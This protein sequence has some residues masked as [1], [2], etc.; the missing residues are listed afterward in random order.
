MAASGFLERL[1]CGSPD[2]PRIVDALGFLGTAACG[3]LCF[4]AC[5]RGLRCAVHCDPDNAKHEKDENKAGWDEH[6]PPGTLALMENSY[7]LRTEQQVLQVEQTSEWRRWQRIILA[8]WIFY[9]TFLLVGAYG[10]AELLAHEEGQRGALGQATQT[11]VTAVGPAGQC[12]SGS[13]LTV[14]TPRLFTTLCKKSFPPANSSVEVTA[15]LTRTFATRPVRLHPVFLY[16]PG[17]GVRVAVQSSG[18]RYLRTRCPG[19]R[20]GTHQNDG[21]EGCRR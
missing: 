4:M 17:A 18:R 15:S 8:R 14:Y 20:R 21:Q 1:I 7:L 2:R 6:A 9:T 3:P 13:V 12:R 10:C 16:Q 11:Y 19:G 5:A